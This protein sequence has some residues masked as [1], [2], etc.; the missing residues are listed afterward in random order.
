M[1]EPGLV[2]APPSEGAIAVEPSTSPV[3]CAAYVTGHPRGTGYHL[4]AWLDV[5]RQ[6]F[7]HKGSYL[8]A[9][10]DGAVVGVL[11]LVFF[12]SRIFGRATVSMPFLNYGGVLAD[13]SQ[14]E[15]A[16]LERAI[17]DTTAAGGAH[18]ELQGPRLVTLSIDASGSRHQPRLHLPQPC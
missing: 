8:A 10:R 12:S 15:R 1:T 2:L 17:K 9:R 13:D 14:V 16:L 7:G 4:P 5:I 11:P 3:A 18:L 6:A